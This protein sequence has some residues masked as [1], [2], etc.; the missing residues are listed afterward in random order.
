M[1]MTLRLFPALIVAVL[2]LL[3]AT[4]ARFLVRLAAEAE[5]RKRSVVKEGR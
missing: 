4:P 3:V 2:G 1:T 5:L